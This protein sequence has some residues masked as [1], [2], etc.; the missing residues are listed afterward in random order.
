MNQEIIDFKSSSEY[1]KDEKEGLKNHTER[2]IDIKDDRFQKLL[3]AWKD[4]TYPL[5]RICHNEFARGTVLATD[6]DRDTM[7]SFVRNINHIA[8]WNNIMSITWIDEKS[9]ADKKQ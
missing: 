4:K 6:D 5:I 2:V 7:D 8:V 3:R 1:F 9:G